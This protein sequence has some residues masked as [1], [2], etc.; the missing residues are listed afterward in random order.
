MDTSNALLLG[1]VA[2]GTIFLGL[3]IARFRILS[4]KGIAFLNALAIGVLCFLFIDVLA[5]ASQI[6]EGADVAHDDR[7]WLLLAMMVAGF[8]LGFLGLVA[9][10]ERFLGNGEASS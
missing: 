2:G 3:P 8:G 4:R 6:V 1:A 7:F 9:Y 10:G 5:G